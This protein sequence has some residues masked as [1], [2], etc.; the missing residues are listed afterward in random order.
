MCAHYKSVG[1]RGHHLWESF[2]H[3]D[4]RNWTQVGL[5]PLSYFV[6][7]PFLIVKYM[8]QNKRFLIYRDNCDIHIDGFLRIK[9]KINIIYIYLKQV[10]I[11]LVKVWCSYSI[12]RHAKMLRETMPHFFILFGFHTNLFQFG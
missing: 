4:P 10:E 5:Y 6:S 1:I 9:I 8:K 3:W 12:S 7:N 2:H 11:S